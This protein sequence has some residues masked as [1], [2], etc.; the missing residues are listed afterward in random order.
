M[1]KQDENIVEELENSFQK[2]KSELRFKCSLE[3]LDK[4]FSIT[5]N[6]LSQGYVAEDLF[7]QISRRISD[8][9]NGWANY[10]HSFILPNPHNMINVSESK[11][12]SEEDRK[13]ILK[14]ISSLMVYVSWSTRNMFGTSEKDKAKYIEQSFEFWDKTFKDK[15]IYFMDKLLEGWKKN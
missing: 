2:L 9:Y 7:L 12:F 4:S 11:V 6:I 10:L 15:M 14:F 3:E 8:Y 1:V 13:E 5:D